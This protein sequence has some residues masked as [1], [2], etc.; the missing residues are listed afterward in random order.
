M[1]IE[2][3][4]KWSNHEKHNHYNFSNSLFDIGSIVIAHIYPAGIGNSVRPGG[5]LIE[6]KSHDIASCVY[7]RAIEC[8]CFTMA[9]IE[10]S[11]R[12]PDKKGIFV[13]VSKTF[14]P[15][16]NA[17]VLYVYPSGYIRNFTRSSCKVVKD[18]TI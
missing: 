12:T 13:Y 10:I 8:M 1:T 5:H 15:A 17:G 14:I 4:P 3:F 11:K 18:D 16:F 2:M 7:A 9:E 6:P